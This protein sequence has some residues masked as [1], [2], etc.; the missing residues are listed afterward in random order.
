MQ[1]MVEMKMAALCMQ[2]MVE[3]KMAASN[4]N[5]CFSSIESTVCFS[6]LIL[7]LG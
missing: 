6:Q 7:W 1:M 3:M 2:M 5:T 4:Q